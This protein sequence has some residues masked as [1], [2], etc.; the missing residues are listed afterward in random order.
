MGIILELNLPTH[1]VEWRKE[2]V[3]LRPGPSVVEITPIFVVKVLRV[4]STAV[5]S[6][7]L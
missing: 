7:N 2:V 3:S 5:K 4:V 1:R 6:G